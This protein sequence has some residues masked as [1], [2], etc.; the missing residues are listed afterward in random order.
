MLSIYK[1]IEHKKLGNIFAFFIEKND[2]FDFSKRPLNIL[3][4]TWFFGVFSQLS[5]PS[6]LKTAFFEKN[7]T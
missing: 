5:K 7:R 6:F 3:I 4:L 1:F 2:T